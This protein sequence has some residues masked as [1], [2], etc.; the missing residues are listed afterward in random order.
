[1]E[2]CAELEELTRE[3]YVAVSTG[4]ISFFERHLSRR[5]SCVVIGTAP[6]EWWDDRSGALAAIRKQMAAGDE[7]KLTAGNMRAYRAGNVGWVADRPVLRLGAVEVA[8]R[9]TSVFV[10]EDGAWRITQQHFSVG[11]PNED[12]FGKHAAKLT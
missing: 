8:C 12:V 11:V 5:E 1:M 10:L 9:H 4:D 7:M 2:R 6:E 3:F